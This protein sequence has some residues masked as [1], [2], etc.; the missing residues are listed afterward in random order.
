MT[1]KEI[2]AV[3]DIEPTLTYFGFGCYADWHPEYGEERDFD[4]CR[5]KL[6]SNGPR[7]ALICDWLGS[8]D[9]TPP[10]EM[11]QWS[12]DLKHVI[13]RSLPSRYCSNGEVI[14]AAIHLGFQYYKDRPNAYFNMC[15]DSIDAI[16]MY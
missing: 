8:I 6:L 13:E 15:K 1:R 2:L 12:Y 10:D 11:Y 7:L 5:E 4:S 14:C 3:I 9:R 16:R